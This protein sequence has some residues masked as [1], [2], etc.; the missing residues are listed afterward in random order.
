MAGH[1]EI[2]RQLTHIFAGS[3]ALLLRWTTWWQAAGLAIAALFFNVIVLPILGRRV[4]RPGDLDAVIRSGIALY[5]LSV[6]ALILFKAREGG[7]DEVARVTEGTLEQTITTPRTSSS[8]KLV[9][10]ISCDCLG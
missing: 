8:T 5:P 3:F 10:V 1:S 7:W 4:F 2:A 9:Q 6:L